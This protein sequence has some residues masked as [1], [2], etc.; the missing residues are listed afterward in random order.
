MHCGYLLWILTVDTYLSLDAFGGFAILMLLSQYVYS[1]HNNI[2]TRY[3]CPS[4]SLS[5]QAF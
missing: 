1:S 2:V 4:P 5:L 3:M